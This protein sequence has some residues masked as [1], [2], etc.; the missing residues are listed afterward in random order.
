[1]TSDLYLAENEDTTSF[2]KNIYVLIDFSLKC[3]NFRDILMN[4][5]EL[6]VFMGRNNG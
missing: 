4:E 1:M 5:N 2:F 6:T 3:L